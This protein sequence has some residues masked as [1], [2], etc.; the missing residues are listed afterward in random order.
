VKG[1]KTGSKK[2]G[3][4][5]REK[6]PAEVALL[7]PISNLNIDAAVKASTTEPGPS[8]SSTLTSDHDKDEQMHSAP[9]SPVPSAD[10]SVDDSD[11]DMNEH[12]PG[13][14]PAHAA[15]LS[16]ASS[17]IEEG[18]AAIERTV[19]NLYPELLQRDE[20]DITRSDWVLD[21]GCGY[22][23]TANASLFV[24]KQPSQ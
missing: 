13:C 12:D 21:S 2:K 18:S 17:K 1:T 10:S 24:S 20:T 16:V 19:R 4:V 8:S 22:S 5:Q 6:I 7:Q 15:K 23:L 11:D 14:V 3:K 9:A